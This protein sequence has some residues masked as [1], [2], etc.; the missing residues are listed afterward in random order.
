MGCDT[1]ARLERRWGVGDGGLAV[2]GVGVGDFLPALLHAGM[3]RFLL[4]GVSVPLPVCTTTTRPH[5]QVAIFARLRHRA[6]GQRVVVATTHITCAF[7]EPPKQIAQVQECLLQLQG[8]AAGQPV[9]STAPAPH[10]P[11]PFA[12]PTLHIGG[13]CSTGA[14][15]HI[16]TG[17][18]GPITYPWTLDLYPSPLH[19]LLSLPSTVRL[20]SPSIIRF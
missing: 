15:V 8:F 16:R 6:S 4:H 11:H 13:K 12:P 3:A 5:V 20:Q 19:Q 17:I 9:V 2:G 10:L 18:A 14:R 7:T 1:G